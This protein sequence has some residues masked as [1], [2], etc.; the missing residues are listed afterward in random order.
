MGELPTTYDLVNNSW[1]ST[2]N[3]LFGKTMPDLK[4]Y[5]AYLRE[6][7]IGKSVKSFVSGKDVFVTSMQYDQKARIF[8]YETERKE[9]DSLLSKPIDINRIKD[10]DSIFEDVQEK[11]IYSGN[12]VLG[13]S[14]YVENS[15]NVTDSTYVL[16]SSMI[17]SGKYIAYS[18]MLRKSE[19]AFASTSSGDSTM[20]IRCFYNNAIR[21]CFEC[22]TTA[23]ASDCFFCH[24]VM[25]SADC[26]FTFNQRG[27]RNMIGNVQLNKEQYASLKNKLISEAIDDLNR[28]KRTVSLLNVLGE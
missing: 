21:R 23:N 3:I 22:V 5:D 27:K 7:L 9:V 8:D 26:I 13:N 6:P 4:E 20:I 14:H 28:K 12:K 19:Y 15:D 10:I 24:N 16:K 17:F 2:T 1:K 25:D 18:Y 11:V